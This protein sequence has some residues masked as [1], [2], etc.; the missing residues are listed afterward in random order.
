MKN[1][2]G[3]YLDEL[4]FTEKDN[5]KNNEKYKIVEE[6]GANNLNIIL[7]L[8]LPGIKPIIDFI[9]EKVKNEILNN[10]KN[11]EK[12]LRICYENE[13]IDQKKRYYNQKLKS[14]NSNIV[15]ELNKKNSLI[16]KIPKNEY[17]K[18]EFLELFLEDYYLLFIDKN[19]NKGENNDVKNKID[20]NSLIRMLKLIIKYKYDKQDNNKVYN[21][22]LEQNKKNAY[23]KNEQDLT[24]KFYNTII[25]RKDLLIFIL[26]FLIKLLYIPVVN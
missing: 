22:I 5:D 2:I 8:K 10:Y 1:T 4:D 15:I 18:F 19:L 24:I 11:N 9:I 23:E 21:Q 6:Q 25:G 14:L 3:L 17:E 13:E 26:S 20:F 7:G 16:S 12:I